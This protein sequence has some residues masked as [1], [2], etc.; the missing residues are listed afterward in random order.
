MAS[1]TRAVSS[2][3]YIKARS[4][5]ELLSPELMRLWKEWE[6]RV[7][8][9]LS[10]FLQVVLIFS[11]NRRRFTS[12]TRIRFLLWCAYLMADWVA[13]VALGVLLNKLGEVTKDMGRHRA[14][15][16]NTDL[17][18]FWAPFLLLHLGGPDT[19][20]AY[21]LED[22][23]LWLRHF[24]GLAVQTG[25]ATYII[26]LGW[27]GSHLSIL[28]LP[29]F[30]A[31]FIKYGE[32]TWALRSA[33]N[34]QLRESMLTPPDAGPNYSKFMEEFTLRQYEGF[35]VISNEVIEARVQVDDPK[36]GT[37]SSR[38][39]DKLN[40]AY[41]LFTKFRRL[42]VNLI[43]SFQ[44]RDSSQSLFKKM[45]SSKDAFEVIEIELGFMFDVLYTKGAMFSSRVGC[46]L[47]FIS[48]SITFVV[49]VF[50]SFSHEKNHTKKTDLAITILL[51]VVAILLE[52]YSILLLVS[53]DW[54][55][56]YLAKHRKIQK[57]IAH[58]Q[59][60]KHPRW[61]NSLGQHSLLSFCLKSKPK[62][63]IKIQKLF[64]IDKILEVHQ[65]KTIQ[66][67]SNELKDSI[68]SHL[69]EEFEHMSSISSSEMEAESIR[70]EIELKALC[71]CRGDRALQNSRLFEDLL[72]S[73]E[74]EFDQSILIWHIATDLCYHCDPDET[75][76]GN[77]CKISK[78]L[79]HYMLYLLV[80]RPFMLPM[81]IGKIRYLDTC[82]ELKSFLKERESMS[83]DIYTSNA[84]SWR[85]SI[86]AMDP[87][88]KGK[89]KPD[90]TEASEVLPNS[91]GKSKPVETKACEMLLNVNT[92]VPP[93]KV[94]GDRS[95]SVLFDACRLASQLQNSLDKKEIWKLVSDVWIEMLTYTASRCSAHDH[96]RQLGQGGEL[97]THVWLLMAHFGLTEQFQISRGHA[98]A[99]LRV[100]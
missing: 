13:T 12:R 32:R 56:L 34:E 24:L 9:L 100:R 15:D 47:R 18:A 2:L 60:G 3:I 94:K 5:M 35:H 42:F 14:L 23:E 19:I 7:L 65:L 87:F 99:R 8:V 97:L 90:Q 6:L 20:T 28:T 88:G 54:T 1:V 75:Q 68:F 58:F 33:S 71:T 84:R 91:E 36:N 10:L 31:G 40:Q 76:K 59:L 93:I 52:L 98:R 92:V 46:F 17:A 96:A 48:L 51:L 4:N 41:D 70:Y 78:Q 38:D 72:W 86:P 55:K 21:A 22:N 81:G 53:S 80:M 69:K 67:V 64:G 66:E 30:L 39:A 77:D 83:G 73:V 61:S 11:G 43:L 82:E 27:R 49:L 45:P 16:G 79:S 37:S 63:G 50:F 26:F 62:V 57:A 74:V 89:S 29:M 95:K 25:I 44:D 85:S